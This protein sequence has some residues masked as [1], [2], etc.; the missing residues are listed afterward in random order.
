MHHYSRVPV[1]ELERQEGELSAS[2]WGALRSTLFA[3]GGGLAFFNCGPNSGFRC[4]VVRTLECQPFSVLFCGSQ[5]H[6]HFQV[7]PRVHTIFA[8]LLRSL[9]QVR[10]DVW[11]SP[12]FDFLHACAPLDGAGV[13]ACSAP[14]AHQT[15]AAETDAALHSRASA[16]LRACGVHDGS[17]FSMC[18]STEL[19]LIVPR[20][21]EK[22]SVAALLRAAPLAVAGRPEAAKAAAALDG[23]SLNAVVFSGR[24]FVRAPELIDAITTLGPLTLLR[25]IA[26]PPRPEP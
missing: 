17:S 14:C 10:T 24:F 7:L 16:L 26:F 3:V 8:A 9:R 2:E 22:L 11:Q 6:R 12:A 15:L 4:F 25:A 1:A 13:H 21:A 18:L 5:L 20:A 23:L 19:L